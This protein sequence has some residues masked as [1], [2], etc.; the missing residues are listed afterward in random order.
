MPDGRIEFAGVWKKFRRGERHDSLRDLVPA[1]AAALLRRRRAEEL[2]RR[3]FWALRDVSFTVAP[4]EAL[5]VIGPNGA[6]KSTVLKILTRL[7][8]P[9]HGEARVRGR[10]G[11]LIELGGSLHPDL[12]GRENVFLQ[13]SVM[14][15]RRAEIARKFDE[16][17]AFSE[18]ADFIDTPVKRY[19]SGMHAR[20]G[21]SVAAHLET[22]VL[23]IDEVL[24]VGDASFQKKAFERMHAMVARGVPA[25]VV[26]HQL[27]RIASLCS[28]ALLL[29]QGRV[30][31]QGPPAECI[32]AYARYQAAEVEPEADGEGLRLLAIALDRPDPVE[33][34][35]RLGVTVRGY[36]PPGHPHGGI[37][38]IRVR[39]LQTGDVVFAT[40]TLSQRVQ[41]PEG[42]FALAVEL[43]MN[44]PAGLYAIETSLG[45]WRRERARSGPATLVRVD[46]GPGFA[47]TVQMNCAMRVAVDGADA[48]SGSVSGEGPARPATPGSSGAGQGA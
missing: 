12:T 27:E 8:R 26:S 18:L 31:F 32:E 23:I 47:G 15:M 20:L 22:D 48:T 10:I 33:S 4:G 13:G 29:T 34:G 38:G 35:G 45:Q 16:I 39:S 37:A 7:L 42:P 3:E 17:V 36:L 5:G 6:G 19:S 2:G 28:A 21:F 25:I 24:A 43:Q 41:L 40:G 11:S 14:G 1:L 44:V 46:G 9:D 30:G